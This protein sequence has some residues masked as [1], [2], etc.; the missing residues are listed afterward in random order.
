LVLDIDD[1]V[2]ANSNGTANSARY[3][4]FA[5]MASA[6]DQVWAGN[7]YLAQH[8]AAFSASVRVLPTVID[9][10]H[11]APRIKK[12]D[13]SLTLVWIGSRSSGKY[14]QNIMPT[15]ESLAGELPHLRLKV[16]SDFSVPS[17]CMP[18]LFVP[19]RASTE[20]KELATSDVGIAPLPEN[21]WTLGKCGLKVLQYMA[22]GLPVVASPVGVQCE[23]VQPNENGFLVEGLEEWRHALCVIARNSQLCWEMGLNGRRL[24]EEKFAVSSVFPKMLDGLEILAA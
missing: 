24:V 18:I 19:W 7:N 9:S 1:A 13:D 20:N 16:I 22:A 17:F 4:R 8:A 12:L 6:C 14:L 3:K 15:L 2:F 5:R 23:M 10:S 11:Y 21:S